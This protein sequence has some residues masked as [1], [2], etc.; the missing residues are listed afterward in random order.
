MIKIEKYFDLKRINLDFH[1]ELNRVGEDVVKD[2][3][4]RLNGG[5]GVDGRQLKSLTPSTIHA[6]KHKGSPNP[7]TPL[8]D[9]GMMKKIYVNKKATR[10]DQETTIIPAKKRAKIGAI[11]QEGTKPYSI[12]VKKA[13]ALGA[14]F[15]SRGDMYF[16][17]SV[18]HPGHPKR[19]WFGLTK[20]I[21]AKADRLMQLALE[22]KLRNA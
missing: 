9:T 7:R 3:I 17:K 10:T 11:H 1:K 13:K 6:K 8:V 16:S 2:H 14:L 15:N 21:E 22:R 18:D 20:K 19:E 12:H 5:Q 4:D